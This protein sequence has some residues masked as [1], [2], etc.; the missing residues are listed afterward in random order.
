MGTLY[1]VATPIGNLAD[2]TYRAVTTLQQVQA[3]LCEDTR[4]TRRLLQ[5]YA[6]STPT[7][8]YHQFTTPE[9]IAKIIQRLQAG[10]NLAMVSD[11]GTPGISDP[12]SKLVQ[13][14]IAAGVTVVPIPG[15][16]AVITALQ[17]SDVDTSE[18]IYLGFIP[19]KRGRQTLFKAI[20]AEQRTVVVYESPHRLLKTL[21]VLAEQDKY[22]IVARELTK[23]HEEFI[24]GDSKAVY[25]QLKARPSIKGECVIVIATSTAGTVKPHLNVEQ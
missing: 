2:I 1:S 24:R 17:A 12:G 21:A 22:I 7:E 23:I 4:V 6:I 5:H 8:V 3:I 9:Q 19:H 15:P 16:S 14:A 13:A 10:S 18:Y 11:A 25:D 20:A